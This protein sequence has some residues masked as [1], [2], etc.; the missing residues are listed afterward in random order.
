M[1]PGEEQG[2]VSLGIIASL[3]S[4]VEASPA[5]SRQAIVATFRPKSQDS[6]SVQF[7]KVCRESTRT[8]WGGRPMQLAGGTRSGG[9]FVPCSA[10]AQRA[11]DV[12]RGRRGFTFV[13]RDAAPRGEVPSS[14]SNRV[15][16]GQ[17]SAPPSL[18]WRGPGPPARNFARENERRQ[19]GTSQ[20]SWPGTM[21]G[22]T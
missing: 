10:V 17:S 5:K 3:N 19:P 16:P 9:C 2:V 4:L 12:E 15:A 7:S 6:L 1:L 20:M 22:E 18:T 11:V 13:A 21:P 8:R 14:P